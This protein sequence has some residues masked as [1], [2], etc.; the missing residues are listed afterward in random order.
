MASLV[1]RWVRGWAA[2][3]LA[4]A[5]SGTGPAEQASVVRCTVPPLRPR[6]HEAAC[7]TGNNRRSSNGGSIRPR[8]VEGAL[9]PGRPK[10]KGSD[11]HGSGWVDP[12]IVLPSPPLD[13][14]LTVRCAAAINCDGTRSA[15][16][17]CTSRRTIP[18]G[19]R[20]RKVPGTPIRE[21]GS[22]PCRGSLPCLPA[23]SCVDAGQGG[24]SLRFSVPPKSPIS[25]ARDITGRLPHWSTVWLIAL[26]IWQLIDR[27]ESCVPP[28]CSSGNDS[29]SRR[30]APER[31]RARRR[32]PR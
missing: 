10:V 30:H 26:R 32:A 25:G 21:A 13:D 12:F 2:I 31:S 15:L 16:S 28:T 9:Y 8:S 23:L 5:A 22:S 6:S 17:G 27:S 14:A 4:R 19:S 11:L 20:S 3:S 1:L 24:N 29:G 7:V 18:A